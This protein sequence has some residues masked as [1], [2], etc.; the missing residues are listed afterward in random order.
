MARPRDGKIITFYSY[1]GGTGRTMA[2]ANVAWILASAGKRVLVV[3]WDLESPGLHRYFAPFLDTE[4]VTELPGV[5][6][7][8]LT[9][10]WA[11]TQNQP[12]RPL[13]WH[14]EYAQA[15]QNT[16]SVDW[17]FPGGGLLHFL[18]AGGRNQRYMSSASLIDWD[19]FYER[20]NGALYF[21][22]MREEMAREYDYT[23][24]DSRTGLSDVA[25]IC[26]LE[27]P[28]VIV[29]AF[30]LSDQGIDGAAVVAQEIETRHAERGIRILPVPMRIDTG[31]R[32][33]M[34][35]GRAM[36]RLRF[37]GLP[38]GLSE[39][40]ALRYW[41]AV[42]VPY[43]PFYAYEEILAA[44]GDEPGMPEPLNPVYERLTGYIT[45]GEVSTCAPIKEDDRRK[46]LRAFTRRT[47][48]LPTP[49]WAT[50]RGYDPQ[51]SDLQ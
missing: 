7:M 46:V 17:E 33:K 19:D 21:E 24:L 4:A 16:V 32:E 45:D 8:I 48:P 41:A 44:F 22:T 13:D 31:E 50:T 28:D 30:T 27:L 51:D 3:D 23:L 18:S 14:R 42:E 26:T 9:Y 10:Q 29:I 25:G 20:H 35:A 11:T 6:D 15:S 12:G 37:E 39:A 34:S 43:R 2:L 36:T 38:S 1:K 47:P 40:E 49:R 5:T